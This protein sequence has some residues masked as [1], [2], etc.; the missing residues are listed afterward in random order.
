MLGEGQPIRVADANESIS[1]LLAE[2]P[3]GARHRDD[4]ASALG[5]M[6]RETDEERLTP[7]NP[8]RAPVEDDPRAGELDS[9]GECGEK[10]VVEFHAEVGA[11][12]ES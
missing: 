6:E 11:S 1:L 8:L 12:S 2:T 10:P 5:E 7:P 4:R 9:P 3:N